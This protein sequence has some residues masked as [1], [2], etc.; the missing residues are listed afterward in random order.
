MTMTDMTSNSG[1][2][3]TRVLYRNG[4]VYSPEDPFAT[5]I[6]IEGGQVAWVGGEGAATAF[7]DETD[8]VID[9]GGRLLT[10]AFVDAHVHMTAAGLGEVGLD[11][12]ATRSR[13]DVLDEVRTATEQRHGQGL[14]LGYGWDDTSWSEPGPPTNVELDRAAYGGAVMLERIDVHSSVVSSA[15]L[16]TF[17]EVQKT[18]GFSPDGRLTGTAHHRLRSAVYADLP[19]DIRRSA[20]R[21]TRAKAASLGIATL[22]EMGGGAVGAAWDADCLDQLCRDEPGPEV[23]RYWADPGDPAHVDH[24]G[25]HGFGG[26]LFVDG[27][28]GSATALLRE[29]YE[30]RPG[31]GQQF[32]TAA[33]VRDHVVACTRAG[34]QTGFHVIGDGAIDVVLA[35]L[36]EAA[37]E[38]G[39]PTLRSL[40]HRLEH[41]EMIRPEH[42]PTMASLGVVASMQPG[43]DARWGGPGGMYDERLGSRY[44]LLNPFAQLVAAGVPLAFGSDAPVIP[45]GAW[46]AVQAAAFHHVADHRISVRAAFAAHTRG[47]WRAAGL[48]GGVLSVG[49]PATFAIWDVEELVV[50]AP[51]GRVAAWS[52][53]P[54]SGTPGLPDLTPGVPL[55]SCVRTVRGGATI[56][57][58]GQ[59]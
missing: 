18:E 26:D 48:N 35:G 22:H 31:V 36:S 46:E 7:A 56:F 15:V 42:L 9:L 24:H 2:P 40:R 59:M 20:Q 33:Q 58:A 55:P 52:T 54:R 1:Y 17:P 23:L 11:L 12:R 44:T 4:A 16:A 32:L 45:L 13:Q 6:L 38:V 34:W 14:I 10:P 3:T 57:D 30:D 41:V 27:S 50:Q 39:L 43:F 19:M 53:D 21:A 37:D 49:S 25:A 47:G 28:L 8:E 51:D 29:P 5:A